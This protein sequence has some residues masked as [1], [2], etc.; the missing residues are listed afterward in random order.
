MAIQHE[1]AVAL[2]TSASLDWQLFDD[3][4]PVKRTPS[5]EPAREP[6]PPQPVVRATVP[7][8]PS[9]APAP[10]TLVADPPLP[11]PAL[12]D[13]RPAVSAPVAELPRSVDMLELADL[14]RLVVARPASDPYV[15]EERHALLVSLRGYTELDGVIPT[16]FHPLV[17]ES[18][19]DLLGGGTAVRVQG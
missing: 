7:V 8:R 19:G 3:L 6:P 2:P 9:S 1:P 15:Q 17:Q 13:S 18:F 10:L 16:R 14:E 12:V 5:P 4:K 11:P